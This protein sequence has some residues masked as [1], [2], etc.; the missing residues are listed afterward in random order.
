MWAAD[1]LPVEAVPGLDIP[2]DDVTLQ[3]SI[4]TVGP[5][6]TV[7]DIACPYTMTG[8]I[9]EAVC[10]IFDGITYTL[11]PG[12][13]ANHFGLSTAISTLGVVATAIANADSEC[14]LKDDSADCKITAAATVM[15]GGTTTSST[16][17]SSSSYAGVT[18]SAL[19]IT[20]GMEKASAIPTPQ[21]TGAAGSLKAGSALA[22]AALA[23]VAVAL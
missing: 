10:D 19:T 2:T 14:T 18:Y 12:Y 9:G 4:V 7:I 16:T 13:E 3:G 6:G 8:A 15:A 17:T 22:V 23:L 21:G 20:A 5:S 11:R 1:N